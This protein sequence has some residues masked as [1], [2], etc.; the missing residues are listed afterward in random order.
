MCVC[1][2]VVIKWYLDLK[3]TSIALSVYIVHTL[4]PEPSAMVIAS[5]SLV[6]TSSLA[7]ADLDRKYPIAYKIN[8]W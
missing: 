1:V 7:I 8:S 5:L 4:S 6:A 2:Y 3:N